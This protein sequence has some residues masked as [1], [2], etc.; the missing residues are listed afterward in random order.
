MKFH[1]A[2]GESY[3]GIYCVCGDVMFPDA[4]CLKCHGE[5]VIPT[6]KDINVKLSIILIETITLAILTILFFIINI[7]LWF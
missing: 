7:W 6:G 1:D 4:T 5:G 2:W 3:D